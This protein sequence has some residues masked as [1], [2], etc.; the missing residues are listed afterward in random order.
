MIDAF[1]VRQT[2]V[3][4]DASA[5]PTSLSRKLDRAK[6]VEKESE[7]MWLSE[8]T[9]LR[10]SPSPNSAIAFGSHSDGVP[11]FPDWSCEALDSD[12]KCLELRS[13]LLSLSEK[14]EADEALRL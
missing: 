12:E 11:R 4:N 14:P 10:Q 8:E 9:G 3:F 1:L 13:K 5:R 2:N 7:S 6:E